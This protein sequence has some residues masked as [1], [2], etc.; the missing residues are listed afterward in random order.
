MLTFAKR[1]YCV[2]QV[3]A[4]IGFLSLSLTSKGLKGEMVVVVAAAAATLL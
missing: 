3:F 2:W 4:A 1:Q